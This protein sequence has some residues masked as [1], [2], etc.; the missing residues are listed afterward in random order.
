MDARRRRQLRTRPGAMSPATGDGG[1][2]GRSACA[3]GSPGDSRRRR[4][5]RRRRRPA[6]RARRRR[7]RRHASA[8]DLAGDL[9]GRRPAA[10]TRR[11]DRS[12][13]ARPRPSPSGTSLSTSFCRVNGPVRLPSSAMYHWTPSSAAPTAGDRTG[14]RLLR[15]ATRRAGVSRS[16]NGI[17]LGRQNGDCASCVRSESTP[18]VSVG[19]LSATVAHRCADARRPRTA[20]G[21]PAAD[22]RRASRTVMTFAQVLHL[23]LRTFPRT[24]SSA[25]EYLVWQRS[26]TNF[27]RFDRR[28]GALET[29][30]KTLSFQRHDYH[31]RDADRDEQPR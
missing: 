15:A 18:G 2:C 5:H 19:M 21:S 25:M 9:R 4:R 27:I 13:C 30:A 28:G 11:A 31:R 26:Q 1:A 10:S 20:T 7:R 8:R 23:T 3:R 16:G 22:G 29:S 17:G 12:R 24:R 6:R 14:G